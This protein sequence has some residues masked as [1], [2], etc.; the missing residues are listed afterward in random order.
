MANNLNTQFKVRMINARIDFYEKHRNEIEASIK[1]IEKYLIELK[2][3]LKLLKPQDKKVN[4]IMHLKGLGNSIDFEYEMFRNNTSTFIIDQST[5][6]FDKINW[7]GPGKNINT[8]YKNHQKLISNWEKLKKITMRATNTQ[9]NEV[10][11][12]ETE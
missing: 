8:V 11:Q 4:W 1:N 2:N 7:F 10:K 6:K 5:T 3:N 9:Q 12:T